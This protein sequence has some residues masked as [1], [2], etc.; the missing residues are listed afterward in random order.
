MARAFPYTGCG[1]VEELRELMLRGLASADGISGVS[2]G[3]CLKLISF[4]FLLLLITIF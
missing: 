1:P 2:E 4:N 3:N